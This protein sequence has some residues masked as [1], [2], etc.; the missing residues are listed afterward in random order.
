MIQIMNEN[1]SSEFFLGLAHEISRKI[2]LTNRPCFASEITPKISSGFLLKV[3]L[4]VCLEISQI[5][6][7]RFH[8]K[9]F[10]DFYVISPSILFGNHPVFFFRKFPKIFQQKFQ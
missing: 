3:S 10:I 2:L 6:L 8:C 1:F 9:N 7:L 5:L 4:K